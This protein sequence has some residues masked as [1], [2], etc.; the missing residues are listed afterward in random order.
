MTV[1]L[2]IYH[3]EMTGRAELRPA[4]EVPGLQTLRV[5]PPQPD[6]NRRYYEQVGA[7]W[8]WTDRLAWSPEEWR[9]Y[10][11]RPELR[12]LLGVLEG[13]EVGYFELEE[14]AGGDVEIALFGLRPE[15]IGRGLGG[16][17][18]TMAIEEAW[19]VPGSTRVWVHTC[20]LD[21]EFA[22]A[23][24]EKRGFRLFKVEEQ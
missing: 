6:V 9:G 24:Y 2:K 18:L 20:T 7:D 21:H 13:E 4:R 3:L 17:L 8:Q 14:Q 23:N 16:A 22:L 19:A 11:C 12:T 1:P 10:A 5:D 15:F